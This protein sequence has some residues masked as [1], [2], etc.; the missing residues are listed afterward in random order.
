MR[1]TFGAVFF[2][3]VMCVVFWLICRSKSKGKKAAAL[4]MI[5]A[6]AVELIAALSLMYFDLRGMSSG[7]CKVAGVGGLGLHFMYTGFRGVFGVVTAFAWFITALFSY[8]FMKDDTN[9]IRYDICNL[10][11]LG[12]T[13]GI[14]VS[15]TH[16]TLPTKLEV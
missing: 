15:Y 8:T 4:I 7:I 13:M 9:V 1:N 2:P 10:L 3:F 5:F 12:A 14:S 11:T 6:T 16:L